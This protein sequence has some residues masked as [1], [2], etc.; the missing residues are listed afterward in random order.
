MKID[1]PPEM[2]GNNPAGF[3]DHLGLVVQQRPTGADTVWEVSAKHTDLVSA[4]TLHGP[5]LKRSRFDVSPEP[6]PDV[7]GGMPPEMFDTFEKITRALDENPTLAARLDRIITTLIAVPDY[8]VP[9]AVEWGSTALS[10]IPLQGAGGTTEPLF[11]R[12][13]VHDV[14]IDL[15][16]T[17]G[18]NSHRCSYALGTAPPPNW[19]RSPTKTPRRR[20]SS[21]RERCWKAPFSEAST[22]LPYS[23][24]KAHQCGESAYHESDRSSSTPSAA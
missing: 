2:F 21:R 13:S 19:S 20:R 7:P 22:S 3:I 6:T 16:P 24:I 11:P 18:P 1:I 14:R 5:A 23:A 10:G 17:A 9:A 4:Q 12:H 15:S 8:Q